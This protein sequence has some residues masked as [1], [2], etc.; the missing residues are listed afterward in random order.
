MLRIAEPFHGAILNHRHGVQTADAL[1]ITVSGDAPPYGRVTVNGV[2][3]TVQGGRFT[4]SIAVTAPE[5]DLTAC[6]EGT[7]GHQEHTVRVVWDKLSRPRYRFS[8]DDN[9]FWLRDVTRQGYDSLFDCFYLDLLRRLHREYGAKFTLNIYYETDDNPAQPFVLTEFPERYRGEFEA[10]ADWLVLAFHAKSNL[11]DR[12]YQYAP[13]EKLMSD[14]AQVEEQIV[15]FAGEQTLAPPTVIHWGMVQPAALPALYAH[16]VR[17]LSGFAHPTDHGYDVHYW[18][19]DAR[20]EYLWTHEA[21]KDFASGIVFS[22]VDIVCN[23]TTV[24]A[25]APT[26]QA[27]ADNPQQAE[28]MDL[29]THE[30]YFWPFYGRYVPDHGDRL[31]AAIRWVTEHGYEPVFFHEGLLGG[32][33]W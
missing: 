9:S 19:D 7:Y 8:I 6:Y 12:P 31:D 15:R 32:P 26:L 20:A 27:C 28:I 25:T 3:A 18:V 21:L 22:R 1:T 16:G 2:P 5:Q 17:T 29:F 30:Q 23:N 14:L 4:A 24:A 10:A 13:V 33:T 11:P